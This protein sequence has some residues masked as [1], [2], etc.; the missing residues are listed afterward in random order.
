MGILRRALS[1]AELVRLP[2][3][4]TRIA[5]VSVVKGH[6][7]EADDSIEQPERGSQCFQ[8]TGSLRQD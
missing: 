7:A 3:P 2:D 5:P 1:V 8:Q 6:D 4:H